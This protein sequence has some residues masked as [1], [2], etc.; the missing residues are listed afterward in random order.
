VVL[1]ASPSAQ[2]LQI[3]MRYNE[4]VL[5]KGTG[6]VAFAKARPFLVTNRHN[7]TGRRQDN[8]Q[9]ISNTGGIPNTVTIF[10]NKRG[11][12]GQW[13]A[14][15]EPLLVNE[16]PRWF[17]HPL[18]RGGVDVV[19]LPLLSI[20]GVDLYPYDVENPGP[21]IAVRPSEPVSVVGFPFGRASYGKFAIW[22]T[23]F[24]ASEPDLDFERLP[25]VLVDCRTRQGQA[26]SPV[27]AYRNGGAVT[28]RDGSTAFF[29]GEVKRLIG[30]YSGR[31]ND[32]S[33][34]GTVWKTSIISEILR[35]I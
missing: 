2:S 35:A 22:A 27:I 3:E 15:S 19:A 20:D 9:P 7:L 4:H 28:M 6:F 25:I 1:I 13:V 14:R 31:I 26:G 30:I 17:E 23:G 29:S 21:D 16:L 34:I 33:D 32:Q 12:L 18:L 24:I 10:H 8:G 11:A 5:A